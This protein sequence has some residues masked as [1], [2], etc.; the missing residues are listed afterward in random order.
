VLAIAALVVL[1]AYHSPP[2]G[3]GYVNALR[4]HTKQPV[5]KKLT[6]WALYREL[7]T[8]EAARQRARGLRVWSV[9]LVMRCIRGES[10]GRPLAV[11]GRYL[12]LFQIDRSYFSSWDW[13]RIDVQFHLAADIYGRR[14][15]QPW[16]NTMRG[17]Y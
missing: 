11:S 1:P 17:F 4:A 5:H 14:G 6:G 10:S 12:G 9:P 15:W 3:A 13:H 16:P 2:R 7:A 8:K